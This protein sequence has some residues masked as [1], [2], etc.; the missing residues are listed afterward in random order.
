MSQDAGTFNVLKATVD[1]LKRNQ[2]AHADQV[3]QIME[4]KARFSEI[5]DQFGSE[6]KRTQNLLGEK[7]S[8]IEFL[9]SEINGL[10]HEKAEK[11]QIIKTLTQENLKI[12]SEL[13]ENESSGRLCVILEKEIEYLNLQIESKDKQLHLTSVQLKTSQDALEDTGKKLDETYQGFHDAQQ[14]LQGTEQE[15]EKYKEMFRLFEKLPFVYQPIK[16]DIVDKK[17]AEFINS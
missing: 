14:F 4:E 11:E 13:A 15:L 9:Q 12:G 1:S 8:E 7:D 6:R 16:D 3:E 2:S 10:M 17:L 5:I